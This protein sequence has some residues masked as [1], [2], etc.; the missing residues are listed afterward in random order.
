M[1]LVA[2]ATATVPLRKRRLLVFIAASS[3][4]S[5]SSTFGHSRN[6]T[7]RHYT[8]E[9]MHVNAAASARTAEMPWRRPAVGKSRAPGVRHDT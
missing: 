1:G 4:T 9:A 5:R 7:K 3:F 2:A 8:R 6:A